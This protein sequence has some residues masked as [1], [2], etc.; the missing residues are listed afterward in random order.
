[1]WAAA[2]ASVLAV[3]VGT[4]LWTKPV[5]TAATTI[6]V[7]PFVN[8]GGNSANA[9]LSEG[10]TDTLIG[11]L[12]QFPGVRVSARS[13]IAAFASRNLT[14]EDVRK[15]LQVQTQLFGRVSRNPDSVSV[16]V[17]MVDTSDGSIKWSKTYE[18]H[19]SDLYAVERDLAEQIAEQL[20]VEL[21]ASGKAALTGQSDRAGAYDAYLKGRYQLATVSLE[22]R[23]RALELFRQAADLDQHYAA[24]YAGLAETYITLGYSAAPDDM[25]PLGREAARKAISLDPKLADPHAMLAQVAERFDRNWAE[26]EREYRAAIQLNPQNAL[27]LTR[28]ALYCMRMLR[29]DD[30]VANGKKAVEMEPHS[31]SAATNLGWIYYHHRQFDPAI[32]EFKRALAIDPGAAWGH[33]LLSGAYAQKGLFK[34][35]IEEGKTAIEHSDDTTHRAGLA[36]VYAESG[37]EQGARRELKL[38]IEKSKKAYVVPYFPAWVSA[39]L[40]DANAAFEFL[41][42]SIAEHDQNAAYV[43]IEPAFD[44]LHADPRYAEYLASLG[45]P[46]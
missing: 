45:L 38:L 44:K 34:E 6:A 13:T 15:Q 29:W 39:S 21:G 20:K 22:G 30:A 16:S 3:A 37:D 2:A 32:E 17:E 19:P 36:V 11:T 25:I 23:R 8:V 27:I 1:M 5:A 14:P 31:F 4:Y 35:A 26:A 9:Y 41:H 33:H 42:R 18:R 7:M 28:Y 10:L 43:R 24:A 40:G 12:S 46:Q